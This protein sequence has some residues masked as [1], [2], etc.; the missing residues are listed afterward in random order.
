[1]PWLLDISNFKSRAWLS[2]GISNQGRGDVPIDPV[3]QLASWVSYVDISR[4]SKPAFKELSTAQALA[5]D[6]WVEYW[7][8][9]NKRCLY[10]CCWGD[11]DYQPSN[12]PTFRSPILTPCQFAFQKL[13][14]SHT[15]W[16]LCNSTA[17][18]MLVCLKDSFKARSANWS[19]TWLT[20]SHLSSIM[21]DRYSN[22]P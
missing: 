21:F 13:A 8:S 4:Q 12:H 6:V 9:E 14:T 11:L 16:H 19:Q 22:Q 18:V 5:R 10:V 15:V 3:V 20:S 2:V 1:M 17:L 7:D